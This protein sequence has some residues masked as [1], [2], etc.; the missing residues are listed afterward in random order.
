MPSDR[1]LARVTMTAAF[2]RM[3]ARMRRSRYSSPGNHGSWSGGMVLTY[4]VETVAGKPTCSSRARSSSFMSRNRPR[5]LPSVSTTASNE[6]SHSVVS[7]GSMSGSWW[8]KPSKITGSTYSMLALSGPHAVQG[9]WARQAVGRHD[10]RL[11]RWS[12]PREPG[13]RRLGVGRRRAG[14]RPWGQGQ[15]GHDQPADG[16]HG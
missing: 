3:K 15:P 4:G 10:A 16:E 11:H 1:V 7:S 14:W 8:A 13:S 5:F 9:G 6:S 2:H 12:V